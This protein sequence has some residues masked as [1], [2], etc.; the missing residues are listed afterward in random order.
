MIPF[1]ESAQSTIGLE[2]EVAL[3]DRQTGELTSRA[4]EVL[5]RLEDENPALLNDSDGAHITGEFLDNTVELVTGVSST[6][7]EGLDQLQQTAAELRAVTDSLDIDF[8]SAGT[9]PF[10]KSL[11]QPVADKERYQ[12]MLDRTQYWGRQMVI[13]GVHVHTGLDSRDK[14]LPV[15]DALTNYYP[16]LLA[17]SASSPFWEGTDS[18]YA[19]QRALLFQQL[20]T[21]G[22]PFNF[23]TWE[24]YE[25]YLNDM[26]TTGVIDDPSEN[27][28]DI[29]PVP[30]YGTVEMRIC[31]GLPSPA[32]IAA[33][34][35]FNQCLV[36][37]VSREF[38]EGIR[39]EALKPWHVQ[40]NKW[41]AA[42][43]GLDGIIIQNNANDE[44][45]VTEDIERLLNKFEPIAADLDCSKELAQVERIMAEGGSYQKQRRVA[46]E[47]DGDLRAV[48][49]HLVEEGKKPW[50]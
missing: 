29:R 12:K 23:E 18:G 8:F 22:L 28:W 9:H 4:Q 30:H 40:E 16:H 24:A 1:A 20:P 7:G 50:G 32:D 49:R 33:I 25:D 46:A 43:Y 2:W 44:L 42:R 35:A 45:L 11:D 14:A 26:L 38:E 34:A 13:Y 31:D 37:S 17:L 21:S 48:V 39:P 10:S 19:S 27:R 41:R 15:L 3:V 6:V 47:N 5:K 36:E